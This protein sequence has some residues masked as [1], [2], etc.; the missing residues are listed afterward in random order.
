M[1]GA[2]PNQTAVASDLP[3]DCATF[4]PA[5]DADAVIDDDDHHYAFQL[6]MRY[7]C[8]CRHKNQLQSTQRDRD[9]LW[10][11]LSECI[12]CHHM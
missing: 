6:M 5:Y 9:Y 11:A 1:H 8:A 2:P 12:V 7:V 10:K 3:L 4:P